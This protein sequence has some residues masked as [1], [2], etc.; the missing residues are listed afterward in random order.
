MLPMSIFIG[1]NEPFDLI[2]SACS[3]YIETSEALS[4]SLS[5]RL[6][7]GENLTWLLHSGILSIGLEHWSQN[8]KWLDNIGSDFKGDTKA[9]FQ[10]KQTHY[11]CTM[12]HISA[13][14]N[15]FSK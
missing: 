13:E 11:F 5:V 1:K 14:Y 6:N 7:L 12:L 4:L 15:D 9:V 8:E 2:S 3:S 10:S